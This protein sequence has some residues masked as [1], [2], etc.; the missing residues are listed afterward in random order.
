MKDSK[1]Y[2]DHLATSY[3]TE[4]DNRKNY[5]TAVDKYIAKSVNNIRV[6][7]FLDI[8]AGNGN[9]SI[10]IANSI[11]VEKEIVLID[12]SS[13]MLEN[14]SKLENVKAHNTSVFDF[15]TS[16]KFDLITCLWNVLGHFNTKEERI[17]LFK[18]ISTLLAPKGVFIFDVNNRYNIN[19]YGLHNVEQNLKNDTLNIKDAGWFTLGEK[20]N[21]TRVYMH[22]PFDINTYID[23]TDLSVEEIKYID[24]TT[25]ETKPTFFEGQLVY[26]ITKL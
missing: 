15:N 19:H 3:N 5:L 6:Y 25:G 16:T 23:Q 11:S 24:Y 8:G 26:K 14:A 7:N 1:A 22:S 9:R 2:Y 10:E 13:K 17:Q 4:S 18:K 21:Q 20:T 12:S